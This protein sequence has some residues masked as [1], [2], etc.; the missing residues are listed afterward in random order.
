MTTERRC[1][2]DESKQNEKAAKNRIHLTLTMEDV[3]NIKLT[4]EMRFVIASKYIHSMIESP[5]CRT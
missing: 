5:L 2:D 3:S 4:D 1:T